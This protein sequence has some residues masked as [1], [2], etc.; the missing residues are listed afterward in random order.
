MAA[1]TASTDTDPY[2]A[3]IADVN[4]LLTAV[5]PVGGPVTLVA[6]TVRAAMVPAM[7][8]GGVLPVILGSSA[9][10]A[11]DLI[12][13]AT[14]GIVAALGDGIEVKASKGVTIHTEDTSPLAI[15]TPGTPA[16]IAAPTRSMFQTDS[17][18][19]AVEE[20]R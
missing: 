6:N 7:A 14:D 18:G 12:A 9:V 8:R 3:M 16:T 5:S 11:A 4:A 10:D 17:G 15:G 2:G 19:N 1:L 13:V 20:S